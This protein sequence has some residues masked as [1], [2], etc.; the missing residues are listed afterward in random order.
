MSDVRPIVKAIEG[1]KSSSNPA[2][3]RLT[4]EPNELW[5]WWQFSGY[6]QE[7]NGCVTDEDTPEEAYW[8][9]TYNWFGQLTGARCKDGLQFY[10]R[11]RIEGEQDKP[12]DIKIAKT[13]LDMNI[14]VFD[15]YATCNCLLGQPCKRHN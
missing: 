2:Q 5:E 4:F 1:N 12:L 8:P 14:T 3:Q 6:K 7:V 9:P 15:S 11:W 10:L 13:R